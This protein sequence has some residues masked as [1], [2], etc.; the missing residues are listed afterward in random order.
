MSVDFSPGQIAFEKYEV[1]RKIAEGGM[2]AVW[3]VRHLELEC[4]RALKTI[5]S[6]FADTPDLRARFQREARV[7]ASFSHPN[8]VV[9]HDARLTETMA[10][11]EMEFVP[12]ESLEAILREGVSMPLPWVVRIVDQL[13]GVLQEAHAKGIVH[14][15]LKPSNLML[16]AG[17]AEGREHLKVL[18]FGLAKIIDNVDTSLSSHGFL[19]T[20]AYASPEQITGGMVDHRSDLYSAGV[21]LYQFLTGYRPF[22]GQSMK[23][24]FQHVTAPPPRFQAVRPDMEFPIGIEEIVFRCLAKDS[25]RRPNSAEE[26]FLAFV[27]AAGGLSAGAASSYGVVSGYP[28]N[29]SAP[30]SWTPMVTPPPGMSH[31]SHLA[32]TPPP[33]RVSPSDAPAV[34][35]NGLGVPSAIQS[36]AADPSALSASPVASN[37]MSG[38]AL[39]P[40]QTAVTSTSESDREISTEVF[41]NVNSL[42]LEAAS[43]AG[44]EYLPS[45]PAGVALLSPNAESVSSPAEVNR[46]VKVDSS[47][48]EGVIAPRGVEL[49][50]L[51]SGASVEPSPE[52]DKSTSSR[53]AVQLSPHELHRIP[54][55]GP[56]IAV[57]MTSDLQSLLGAGLD[58]SL[59]VWDSQTKGVRRRVPLPRPLS[60][61]VFSPNG[62]QALCVFGDLSIRCLDLTSG[63]ELSR[64]HPHRESVGC[65]AMSGLSTLGI[66]GGGDYTIRVWDYLRG[67]QQMRMTGHL[68][69]IRSIALAPDD[70]LGLSGGEDASIR[71]WDL[72]LGQEVSRFDWHSDWVSGV[73]FAPQ[74]TRF[75]SIGYDNLVLVWDY[76]V[77]TRP[78]RE[79][80]GH[81]G[82]VLALAPF[83]EGQ[84]LATAGKD[85][86]IRIWDAELGRECMRYTGHT[87]WVTSLA[88]SPDGRI[89]ISGSRDGTIRVW[90]LPKWNPREPVFPYDSSQ[91]E[92]IAR[93]SGLN[94]D[95]GSGDSRPSL[96]GWLFGS[97]KR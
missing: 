66:S 84:L 61:C 89:L 93:E 80:H 92:Q 27:E 24:M 12:G 78:I 86:T 49:G 34:A 55:G 37:S 15:D 90:D 35:T 96:L 38:S 82:W 97:K 1:V 95:P 19:G 50:T 7:M 6:R 51:R 32:Y 69:A 58:R 71:L 72:K 31:V 8:A 16:A 48:A 21:L 33:G 74:G 17:R 14:R 25:A 81:D 63:N 30:P 45:V 47:H 87:D 64:L 60:S 91:P 67:Q 94:P 57:G 53:P 28:P 77:G 73:A 68:G 29:W 2:G 59:V 70:T 62:K 88:I 42:V 36:S 9:V 40:F 46:E 13:C 10:Y 3:L 23:I 44:P 76:S 11:I 20:A 43:Q 65:V 5:T 83:A 75:F 56:V 39:R 79:L 85:H 41:T 52:L 4:E 54:F 18:D 22:R 26:L